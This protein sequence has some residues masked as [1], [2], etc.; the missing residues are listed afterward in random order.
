[1]GY[2]LWRRHGDGEPTKLNQTS[3]FDEAARDR[4]NGKKKAP[5]I[6]NK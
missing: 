1:M 5:E 2:A 4:G 6:I 3:P